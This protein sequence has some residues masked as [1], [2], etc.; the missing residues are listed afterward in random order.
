MGDGVFFGG[1]EDLAD[2]GRVFDIDE[3]GEGWGVPFSDDCL[4]SL[5]GGIIA[6]SEVLVGVD[7]EPR[8]VT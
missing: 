4:L 7:D 8:A 3:E 5:D 1:L 2:V 6:A